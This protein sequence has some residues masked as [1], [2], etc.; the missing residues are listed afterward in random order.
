[1]TINQA[2]SKVPLISAGITHAIRILT[3]PSFTD[4]DIWCPGC[5]CSTWE[6]DGQCHGPAALYKTT[7]THMEAGPHN[8]CEDQRRGRGTLKK[9]D[10]TNNYC[11]D[12]WIWKQLG[13]FPDEPCPDCRRAD[14]DTEAPTV[15]P[16]DGFWR[17]FSLRK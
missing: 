4:P 16:K 15:R 3:R 10:C 5:G 17:R 6:C 12:G 11:I 2:L 8:L 7:G 13:E 9:Q 1:M 14:E